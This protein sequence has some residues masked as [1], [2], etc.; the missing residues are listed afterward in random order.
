MPLSGVQAG[1]TD[2]QNLWLR[3]AVN[4]Q[5]CQ[6]QWEALVFI[7]HSGRKDD[8]QAKAAR[9]QNDQVLSLR[10]GQALSGDLTHCPW[11]S[12][13]PQE[14]HLLRRAPLASSTE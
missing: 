5:G 3:L 12:R 10:L 1:G 13:E 9:V 6:S 14:T 11:P 2:Q 7:R 8:R 4:V